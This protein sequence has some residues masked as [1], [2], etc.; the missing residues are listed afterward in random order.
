MLTEELIKRQEKERK[1]LISEICDMGELKTLN[2]LFRLN[3]LSKSLKKV[4]ENPKDYF[5][6]LD[7]E[8]KK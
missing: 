1:A 4:T 6:N 7:N 2:D 8:L 5:K 3:R